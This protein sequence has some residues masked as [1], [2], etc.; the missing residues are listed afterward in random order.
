M[1]AVNSSVMSVR[2]YQ[3]IWRNN[4][5]DGQTYDSLKS[6]TYH[7]QKRIPLNQIMKHV[8]QIRIFTQY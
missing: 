3:N 1:E 2:T 6:Y 4:P 8:R 5:E 7:V